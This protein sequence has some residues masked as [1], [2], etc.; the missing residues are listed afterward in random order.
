MEGWVDADDGS[1][2]FKAVSSSLLVAQSQRR[3]SGMPHLC[4]RDNGRAF[5][6]NYSPRRFRRHQDTALGLR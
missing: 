6:G 5:S 1:A 3:L 2:V 4:P